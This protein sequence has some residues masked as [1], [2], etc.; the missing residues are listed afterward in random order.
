MLTG[1][2][3]QL[4]A[5]MSQAGP[6]AQTKLAEALS[7][8]SDLMPHVRALTQL[9]RPRVLDDLGLQPALEWHIAQYQLQA[10]IIVS[11]DLSLPPGRLPGELETVV[12]RITQESLTNIARHS[13]C[14]T[15]AINITH[16][17][18]NLHVEI[19]D[20]GCGFDLV[21]VLGRR[22]A[23]GIAGMRERVN[24]AGGRLESISQPGQGARLN[25]QFPLPV[26]SV[27]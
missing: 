22:D 19:S 26:P 9:Y 15:A 8:A 11:L 12:F 6:D 3:F 5:A 17:Q 27:R 1:L 25:A 13:G 7:T 24:L 20:R 2:K 14:K 16:D 4:E 18:E 21:A 10:G 23:F